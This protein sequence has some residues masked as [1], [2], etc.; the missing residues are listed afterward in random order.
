MQEVNLSK[1][2]D[3][4]SCV[5]FTD[6]AH[7]QICAAFVIVIEWSL[8]FIHWVRGCFDRGRFTWR[9]LVLGG[10]RALA[11]PE[12]QNYCDRDE[13]RDE[14]EFWGCFHMSSL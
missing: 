13:G 2:G 1:I 8:D 4:W 3:H 11:Q 5:V 10:D 14:F 9:G 7:S 6:G 12:H